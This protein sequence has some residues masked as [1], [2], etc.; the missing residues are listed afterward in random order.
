MQDIDVLT[1]EAI[2]QYVIFI[3]GPLGSGKTVYIG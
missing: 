3:M 2:G 1:V